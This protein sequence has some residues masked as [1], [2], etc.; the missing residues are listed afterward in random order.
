MSNFIGNAETSESTSSTLKPLSRWVKFLVRPSKAGFES[1]RDIAGTSLTLIGLALAWELQGIV[2][3]LVGTRGAADFPGIVGVLLSP[4]F[5]LIA[6]SLM[7]AVI[8]VGAKISGGTGTYK[9]QSNVIAL[10]LIPVIVVDGLFDFARLTPLYEDALSFLAIRMLFKIYFVVTIALALQV[11]HNLSATKAWIIATV[12]MISYALFLV[13][14]TIL[15][16]P[17]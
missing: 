4:I 12:L 9:E 3:L 11:V 10:T 6:Y 15:Y 7:Q 14:G 16:Y 17:F 2:G 5:W 1:I 8:W 13:I